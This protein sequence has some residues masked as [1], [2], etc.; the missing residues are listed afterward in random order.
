MAL[1]VQ[2]HV[3]I[4]MSGDAASR[5]DA[6]WIAGPPGGPRARKNQNQSESRE[7]VLD[8][9]ELIGDYRDV[10]KSKLSP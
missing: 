4:G 3:G 10:E 6:S 8:L 5:C 7:V 9:A 1:A 2:H